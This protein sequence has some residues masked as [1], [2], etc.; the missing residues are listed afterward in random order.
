MM[1]TLMSNITFS[2]SCRNSIQEDTLKFYS[3][4]RKDDVYIIGHKLRYS[5]LG[6]F[7]PFYRRSGFLTPWNKVGAEA[8]LLASTV[9]LTAQRNHFIISPL[10]FVKIREVFELSYAVQGC[11]IS[12]VSQWTILNSKNNREEIWNQKGTGFG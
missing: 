7:T 10:L 4:L 6:S 1:K 12:D 2:Y 3:N 11:S 9:T 8:G 5:P